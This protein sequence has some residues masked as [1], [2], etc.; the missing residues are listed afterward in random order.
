[1]EHLQRLADSASQTVGI[2]DGEITAVGNPVLEGEGA[3]RVRLQRIR[4]LH[5]IVEA[6]II[7]RNVENLQQMRRA[8]QERIRE[9]AG[10]DRAGDKDPVIRVRHRKYGEGVLVRQDEMNI[11]AEFPGYGRKTF[12]KAFGDLEFM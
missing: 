8:V 12:L 6:G 3:I 11:E 2:G 7:L 10:A 4:R 9:K 1:M 5:R